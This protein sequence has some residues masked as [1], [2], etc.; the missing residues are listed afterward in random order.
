MSR[1]NSLDAF[2]DV[3][4]QGKKN[5]EIQDEWKNEIMAKEDFMVNAYDI[6]TW[7]FLF[8][9]TQERNRQKNKG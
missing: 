9:E 2:H 7:V 6:F 5:I 1:K 3:R 8:L 4:I